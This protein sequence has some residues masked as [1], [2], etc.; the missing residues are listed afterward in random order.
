MPENDYETWNAQLD[1]KPTDSKNEEEC[2]D[3]DGLEGKACGRD[4]TNR[5]DWGQNGN[6]PA[7]HSFKRLRLTHF[8]S[9]KGDD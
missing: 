4:Q 8:V 1:N 2:G 6:T 5:G 9:G 7:K 3:D